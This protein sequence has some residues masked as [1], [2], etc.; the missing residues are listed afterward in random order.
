M[1]NLA[2]KQVNNFTPPL[3]PSRWKIFLKFSVP[4][5]A[6]FLLVVYF[7]MA[8]V[9]PEEKM[10][11]GVGFLLIYLIL[12]GIVWNVSRTLHNQAVSLQEYA[13]KLE[14]K[15]KERTQDL[16]ESN[17]REVAALKELSRLK[18]DFVFIAAHEV[19]SPVTV[20]QWS[21]DKFFH[22]REFLDSLPEDLQHAFSVMETAARR[23][24]SLIVDLLS[25][26][27]LDSGT[28]TFAK[29]PLSLN[30]L[31][32]PLLEE[33]GAPAQEKDISIE[34]PEEKFAPLPQVLGDEV[35]LKEVFGNLLSNAIKFS[36]KGGEIKL[37][38]IEDKK[39][40][41][42]SV[43]DSG[44]G[45]APDDLPKLFTKFFRAK[46]EIDGTGLGLWISQEIMRRMGGEIFAESEEGKGSTFRV[47]IPR[48]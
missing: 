15:V 16:E 44:I 10:L 25:V 22:Q 1:K 21:I 11:A 47:R 14:T 34:Y 19:R 38:A 36:K 45:I 29:N 30:E 3:A 33:Y 5:L 26:A 39:F 13:T 4:T 32:K 40:V 8:A 48:G 42:V 2:T 28:I 27:R 37:D 18:D 41:T 7:V 17:K 46:E 23:L 9:G 6:V 31:L 20:I 43:K 24:S 12:L 35:R